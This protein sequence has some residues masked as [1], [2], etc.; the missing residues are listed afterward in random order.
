MAE[1]LNHRH[2][3]NIDETPSSSIYVS[4]SVN[5]PGNQDN[6]SQESPLRKIEA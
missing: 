4:K 6:S 3:M 2:L 1:P 5:H